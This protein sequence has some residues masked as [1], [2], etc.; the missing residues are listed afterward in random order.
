MTHKLNCPL[1]TDGHGLSVTGGTASTRAGRR[2]DRDADAQPTR[3]A[4]V[5]LAIRRPRGHERRPLRR[6]LPHRDVAPALAGEWRT[7]PVAPAPAQGHPGEPRHQVQL[8]RPH[9]A[10]RDRERLYL[11]VR[12]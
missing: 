3:P 4:A 8:G 7:L 2:A 12:H 10:E 1:W 11:A 5:L 9:V 6:L